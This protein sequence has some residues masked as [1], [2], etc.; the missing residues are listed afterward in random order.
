MAT[1]LLCCDEPVLAEGL[2]VILTQAG[3]FDLVSCCSNVDDLHSQL[4]LHQPDLLLMDLT[5]KFTFSLL[6]G[7]QNLVQH[8][9]IILWVHSISTEL[10]LQ[11][12]SLGVRGVLR[13]TV[14]I[15]ALR[16]GLEAIG[17]KDEVEAY[18]AVAAPERLGAVLA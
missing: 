17:T 6:S 18:E 7:L 4:E 2:T 13:K 16:I 12:M 5:A 1:M 11:A 3:L 9:K 15:E 14:P 8:T 10:A